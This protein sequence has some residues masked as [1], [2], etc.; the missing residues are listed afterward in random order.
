MIQRFLSFVSTLMG[1]GLIAFAGYIISGGKIFPDKVFYTIFQPNSFLFIL[2][3]LT[4][5]ILISHGLERMFLCLW[6]ILTQH[7]TTVQRKVNS[8]NRNLKKLSDVYYAKGASGL[9]G[10]LPFKKILPVWRL[11]IQQLETKLP[12]QDIQDLL[13]KDSMEYRGNINDIIRLLEFHGNDC[14]FFGRFG[15]RHR[16]NQIACQYERHFY[17]WP[18]YVACAHDNLVRIIFRYGHRQT[19]HRSDRIHTGCLYQFL[20]AGHLLA[21]AYRHKETSLLYRN[22]L[23]KK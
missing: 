12:I 20:P 17:D 16:V 6:V 19:A 4:G 10:A 21:G 1:L 23:Y 11:V 22:E 18:Q 8:L 15:N 13:E 3:I 9:R 14:S 7:P 2:C 5:L